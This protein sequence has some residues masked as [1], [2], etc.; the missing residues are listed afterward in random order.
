MADTLTVIDAGDVAEVGSLARELGDAYRNR[1][2]WYRN[3]YGEQWAEAFAER[4]ARSVD[5]KQR[6]ATE[7]PDQVSYSSLGDLTAID[8]AAA[9]DAWQRVKQAARDE[10]TAGHRTAE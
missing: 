9:Q 5:F 4:E 1:I 7:P 2:E 10:L 8:P 6:A 3:N